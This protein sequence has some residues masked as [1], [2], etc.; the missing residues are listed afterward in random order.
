MKNKKQT[1]AMLL[2]G[3]QGSRLYALTKLRAKPA[4]SFGG[5]YRII[6]F[7]LSNCIH[8]G[9]DTVGVLTQYEPLELNNYIGNGAPWDMDTMSG[10]ALVLPPY[11]SGKTGEWYSGTANAI[12]QNISFIDQYDPDFVIVLSGDHIYKMNYNWMIESHRQMGADATIAVMPV[13]LREASR[14]GI[15][16]TDADGFITEFEEKPENPQSNLASMGVY[17][18]SWN[19]LKKY[20]IDDAEDPESENDFGNNIIPN[21]LNNEQKLFAYEFKGYWKD[22]GTIRSLWEANMEL[23]GNKPKLN[24]DDEP[25]K[26]YTR[27][28]NEPPQYI[29]ASSEIDN[30]IICEGCYIYGTVINSVLSSGVIVEA[31]AIVKDSVIMPNTYIGENAVVEMTIADEAC[32]IGEGAK[33][34]ASGDLDKI[35][36]LG[37]QATICAGEV[38]AAGQEVATGETYSTAKEDETCGVNASVV[39]DEA[40]SAFAKKGATE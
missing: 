18:F 24:L 31:G 33:I 29:A 35:A 20:L 21:M 17:C 13:P 37:K 32:W 26:I 9:I 19:V 23:L 16:T 7:P 3:G 27:N 8:S 39:G 34:G 10:G 30:S 2:A 5:K 28:P 6:D 14:F 1:V 22:V 4:V 36:L 12:Y 11:V 15:M 25:W 40:F 38:I